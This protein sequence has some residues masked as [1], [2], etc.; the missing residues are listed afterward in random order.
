MR[1]ELDISSRV[2]ADGCLRPFMNA[3]LAVLLSLFVISSFADGK[4]YSDRIP[5]EIPYQRAILS[6]D[7]RMEAILIESKFVAREAPPR[8]SPQHRGRK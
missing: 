7:G 4:F 5:P 1:D 3:L 8:Y 2:G 6:H